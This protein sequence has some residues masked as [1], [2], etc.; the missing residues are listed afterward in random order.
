MLQGMEFEMDLH[1]LPI[2]EPDI[3]LGI[4]W[5]QS[6]GVA[7]H[8]YKKATM[9]FSWKITEVQLRGDSVEEPHAVTFSQL[10]A[11]IHTSK[12]AHYYELHQIVTPMDETSNEGNDLFP[13]E[14]HF[15]QM[16]CCRNSK[17]C[18]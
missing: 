3:V 17:V 14:L 13:L 15:H 11:L 10:Q 16:S 18:L 8:D 12:I 2:K 6:L 9:A 5:L 1:V 4:Q 7:A